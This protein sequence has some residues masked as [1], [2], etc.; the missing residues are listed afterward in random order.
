MNVRV[1]HGGWMGANAIQAAKAWL[2]TELRFLVFRA[3]EGLQ[4]VLAPSSCAAPV[5]SAVANSVL[6]LEPQWSFVAAGY[7]ANY[8]GAYYKSDTCKQQFGYDRPDDP[9]EQQA[10]IAEINAALEEKG[11]RSDE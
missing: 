9:A 1:M 4:L 3:E 11:I 2:D 6:K 5:H 10:L 8:R 7:V